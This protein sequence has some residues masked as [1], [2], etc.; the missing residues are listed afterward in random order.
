MTVQLR[1]NFTALLLLA[2]CAHFQQSEQD[3]AIVTPEIAHYIRVAALY[4][5]SN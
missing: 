5:I 3:F 4:N 1:R 2:S